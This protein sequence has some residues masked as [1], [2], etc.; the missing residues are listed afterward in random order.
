MTRPV[1]VKVGGSLLDWPA[2]PTGWPSYLASAG[3]GD[4][5]V[6]DRRRRPGG[7]RRP[8][9]RPDSRLGEDAVAPPGP[10]VARPDRARPRRPVPG[11]ES[12]WSDLAALRRPGS[13]GRIPVLAPR[14]FLDEIDASSPDPLPHSWDVTTDSIAARVAV[15]LG[16]AELVLLKSAPAARRDR[17]RARPRPARPGRSG[18]PGAPRRPLERVDCYRRCSRGDRRR[19]PSIPLIEIEIDRDRDRADR[20]RASLT[21]RPGAARIRGMA[22]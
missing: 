18:L 16:A 12:W 2:S 17:P 10:P 4:R 5:L 15:H 20:R 11:L 22:V 14:R 8:R 21:A 19:G 3:R 7:R 13:R 9:P 1:V 6:A